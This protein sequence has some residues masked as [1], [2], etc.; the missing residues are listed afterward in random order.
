MQFFSLIVLLFSLPAQATRFDTTELEFDRV[1]AISHCSSGQTGVIQQAE[2]SVELRLTELLRI[3]PQYNLQGVKRDYVDAE[4]RQWINGNP[5]HTQYQ[6]YWADVNAVWSKMQASSRAGINFQCTT[7]RDRHCQGGGVIAYVLFL[8]GRPRPKIYLCPPFFKQSVDEQARTVLHEL[9]HYAASTE[10]HAAD[11]WDRS[12]IDLK[13]AAEDA[14][15]LDEFMNSDPMGLLKR[16][17]WFWFW[18]KQI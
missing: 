11:W 13:K 10:D 9:S 18:P 1:G 17:I 2:K 15:H 6:T 16:M 3:W 4:N 8:F 14:H 7:E 5:K 12:N